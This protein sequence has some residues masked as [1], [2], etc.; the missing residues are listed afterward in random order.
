MEVFQPIASADAS[1]DSQPPSRSWQSPEVMLSQPE[2]PSKRG[3]RYCGTDA[4]YL[5]SPGQGFLLKS[6]MYYLFT[7]LDCGMSYPS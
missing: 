3:L 6:I 1:A 2:G 5:V 7:S 4:N